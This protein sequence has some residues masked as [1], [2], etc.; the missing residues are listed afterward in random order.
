MSSFFSTNYE[1]I[2]VSTTR[3]F[4]GPIFL[5]VISKTIVFVVTLALSETHTKVLEI[6]LKELAACKMNSILFFFLIKAKNSCYLEILPLFAA[7][8]AV[9]RTTM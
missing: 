2:Q 3:H 5:Y 4:H 1:M 9:V 8:A 7:A 6:N